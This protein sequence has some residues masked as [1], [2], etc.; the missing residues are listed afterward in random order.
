[1]ATIDDNNSQDSAISL[2]VATNWARS[3]REWNKVYRYLFL[4][5]KDFFVILP[6]RK[7]PIAHQVVYHGDVDLLKRMLALFSDDQ[8]D[9]NTKSN[10][11]KTLLNVAID[12][13]QSHGDMFTYVEHLFSQ[14]ELIEAA[15][16]N[17][18]RCVHEL[19]ERKKELANEKPPYS[20]YFLL[21]YIVEYGDAQFLQQILDNFQFLT[22][23]LNNRNETPLDMAIRLQK[24]DMR[25]ILAP[26]TV[27]WRSYV[28]TDSQSPARDS[29]PRST[30]HSSTR[31]SDNSTT[32]QTQFSA[33]NP[34]PK[35]K[36]PPIGFGGIVVDISENGDFTVGSSPLFNSN[37]NTPMPVAQP[38]PT[39][40]QSKSSSGF[41]HVYT[42]KTI[43]SE[44][45]LTNQDP[46]SPPPPPPPPPKPNPASTMNEQLKKN[47]TC[48]LT[49]QIFV[50]PVIATDGHTYE[51]AAIVDWVNCFRC[52]P[53]TGAQMDATFRD[54]TEIKDIIKS[55]RQQN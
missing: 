48:T 24:N 15:K 54:N 41:Q 55:I 23:V 42:T 37:R 6:G 16:R 34:T 4:H 30:F 26:K 11:G 53:A 13:R 36:L 50:D 29:M 10:D 40:S 44:N 2:E 18:W 46:P 21:H 28:R 33:P 5:P 27:T 39:K 17:N 14:N 1:M 43:I 9:L 35:S 3:N 51:R 49:E 31:T 19:L 32:Y 20:P 12:R 38:P 7:W 25:D 47:L 22:N 52:S 45:P 8:I